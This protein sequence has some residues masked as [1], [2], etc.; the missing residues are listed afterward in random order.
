MT[1]INSIVGS[2]VAT[3]TVL[4]T[5]PAETGADLYNRPG[6]RRAWP[7]QEPMPCD[8]TSHKHPLQVIF[9][10]FRSGLKAMATLGY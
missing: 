3:I 7:S 2:I 4:Q 5:V 10:K 8:H 9:N 1:T 6:Q